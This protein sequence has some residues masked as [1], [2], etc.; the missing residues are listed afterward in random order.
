MRQLKLTLDTPEQNLA[1]DEALLDAAECQEIDSGVLRL[2]ESPSYCVVLGRSSNADTEV[3]LSAC[4]R[5]LVPVLRRSSGGGT[6]VM[7]PGCL[8]YALVL[9]FREF[10][11]LQ[12]IDEAHRFVLEQLARMLM[13]SRID[14]APA[15]TSDLVVEASGAGLPQKFSGNA[16]RLKRSHLLYHGTLLYDFELDRID[17]W[18]AK[19]SRVPAY[20][21]DRSHA[22][23]VTNLPIERNELIAA[24]TTGW[25]AHEVLPSWPKQRTADIVQEKYVDNAKWVIHTPIDGTTDR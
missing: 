24:L 3:D 18:L 17:R 9:S 16:M 12:A 7:G 20:R 6:I 2:W 10:P 14:L 25:L 13:S 4:R 5:D 15:G 1:L 23:F 21:R 22:Q 11:Q 8:M 19:A